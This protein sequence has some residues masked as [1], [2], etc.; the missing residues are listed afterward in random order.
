MLLFLLVE[1]LLSFASKPSTVPVFSKKQCLRTVI[2]RVSFSDIQNEP[3][4]KHGLKH[5]CTRTENQTAS[6]AQG[7]VSLGTTG[8]LVIRCEEDAAYSFVYKE[9]IKHTDEL[10]DLIFT[11]KKLQC[12]A[13]IWRWNNKMDAGTLYISKRFKIGSKGVPLF[14]TKI[15]KNA[16]RIAKKLEEYPLILQTIIQD[17]KNERTVREQLLIGEE[18]GECEIEVGRRDVT[19][20]EGWTLWVVCIYCVICMVIS[21]TGLL[22]KQKIFFDIG[23][24]EDWAEKICYGERYWSCKN[25][26]LQRDKDGLI[27]TVKMEN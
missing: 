1:I 6:V 17:H 23:N 11:C 25:I 27:W 8:E 12:I 14:P 19:E 26:G 13:V 3:S 24:A 21:V 10:G 4:L 2:P 7:Y 20:V 9:E 16:H 5:V 22:L 15:M 18:N